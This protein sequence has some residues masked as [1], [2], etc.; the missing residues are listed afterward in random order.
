[1]KNFNVKLFLLLTAVIGVLLVVSFVVA[2]AEDEGIPESNI[3]IDV[4]SKIFYILRFPTHTLFLKFFSSSEKTF[5][6]GLALNGLFFAL[7]IERVIYLF[8]RPG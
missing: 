6:T 7:V 1:M 2:L 3:L 8:K 5:F 4:L